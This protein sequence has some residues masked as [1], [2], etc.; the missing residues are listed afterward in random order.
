MAFPEYKPFP[1]TLIVPDFDSEM[2]DLVIDLDHL[3]KKEIHT[4]THPHVYRD[5]LS[6]FHTIEAIGSAR[7]EGNTTQLLELMDAEQSPE[8]RIPQG[9]KE[10]RNMEKALVFIDRII[11]GQAIDLDFISEVHRLIMEDLRPPP[12][13]DGDHRPG[14]FRQEEVGIGHASHLPPPPWEIL[15][16]M[17]ELVTFMNTDHAPKYDLIKA[18]LFHHRFVW[19]HPFENGNGR[20]ARLLTYALMIKQ[21]F[22]LNNSRIIN[23]TSVF[24]IDRNLYYKML[25]VADNGTREGQEIWCTYM[26]RGLRDEIRKIDLLSNHTYLA[27]KIIHSAL[28]LSEEEK[29]ITSRERYML[30][31]AFDAGAV[32]A[33]HYRELFRDKTPQE[34]SRR[35]R[36]LRNK[37]LLLSIAEGSRKYVINLKAGLLRLGIMEALDQQGFL[38][39]QL[40]TNP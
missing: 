25:S 2:A 33:T 17:K 18:A 36:G 21:G 28:V 6:L 16:L 32:S 1:L 5:L 34:I 40:P 38:P 4:G 11:N 20:T 10:I 24:C 26:L 35:I 19:I 3:R 23:P 37:N 31:I 7:I 8:S 30:K 9:V 39:P 13:G 12:A 15:P 29:R 27:E 14:K 22:R